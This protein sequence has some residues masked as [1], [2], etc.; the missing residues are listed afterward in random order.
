M[1]KKISAICFTALIIMLV[2]CD[3]KAAKPKPKPDYYEEVYN[4]P[5]A[6][7]PAKQNLKGSVKT[8][9][10]TIKNKVEDTAISLINAFARE[11]NSKFPPEVLENLKNGLL[12]LGQDYDTEMKKT[13]FNE[14]ATAYLKLADIKKSL[15]FDE[16]KVFNASETQAKGNYVNQLDYFEINK[17]SYET[18]N[19]IRKSATPTERKLIDDVFKKFNITDYRQ[20]ANDYDK[21][22][23]FFSSRNSIK[24]DNDAVFNEMQQ[25]AI[26]RS[27]GDANKALEELDSL[28]NKYTQLK[29]FNL[30]DVIDGRIENI[31][32]Q[33]QEKYPNDFEKQLEELKKMPPEAFNK[34]ELKYDLNKVLFKCDFGSGGS[35]IGILC[36][37]NKIPVILGNKYLIP[38]SLPARFDNAALSL[39]CSRMIVNKKYKVVGFIVD[40]LPEDI[41]EIPDLDET[42]KIPED[43]SL[44]MVLNASSGLCVFPVKNNFL[45]MNRLFDVRISKVGVAYMLDGTATRAYDNRAYIFRNNYAFSLDTHASN[46]NF[47]SLTSSSFLVDEKAK[48]ICAISV[49]PPTPK[50]TKIIFNDA[51]NAAVG[52]AD[53]KRSPFSDEQAT[54]FLNSRGYDRFIPIKFL[55]LQTLKNTSWQTMTME[56]YEK[57]Q[58]EYRSICKYNANLLIAIL[59]RCSKEACRNGFY[60]QGH[61]KF[62]ASLPEAKGNSK[63]VE[64][65]L[66]AFIIYVLQKS[67]FPAKDKSFDNYYSIT[68]DDISQ[69]MRINKYLCD[70]YKE[71]MIDRKTSI[72][73]E[74]LTNY[75][76]L[77]K[78]L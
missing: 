61:A 70:Y 58:S 13:W 63:M 67:A 46:L 28:C 72:F 44:S 19:S 57:Q 50:L 40:N 52:N 32:K 34:T 37:I 15:S 64:A 12:K 35:T 65:K 6:D 74:V 31:K 54:M 66:R 25:T 21:W 16:M 3:N 48:D 18:Y 1:T 49:Q 51:L 47:T 69:Q 23:A 45:D 43:T 60:A 41:G 55:S 77:S 42:H 29:Q 27:Q 73:N 11:Q 78:T 56:E 62:M 17:Q 68:K 20:M 30:Y 75:V 22:R 4:A 26:S 10:Q 14:Q 36:R 9:A 59:G 2:S 38:D 7:Q 71:Q 33:L 5:S 39:S 53:L 8:N 24:T 76:R